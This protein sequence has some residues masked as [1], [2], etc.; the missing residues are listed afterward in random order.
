MANVTIII[1]PTY[2]YLIILVLFYLKT[3]SYGRLCVYIYLV[4]HIVSSSLFNVKYC[5]YNIF[6]VGHFQNSKGS[7]LAC[8]HGVGRH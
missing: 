1:S 2:T 6:V 4:M 3:E 5:F 7:L 8:G